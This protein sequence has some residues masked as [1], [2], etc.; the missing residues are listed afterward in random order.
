MSTTDRKLTR[1][2]M[3]KQEIGQTR[4]MGGLAALLVIVF[5]LTIYLPPLLQIAHE[6]SEFSRGLRATRR[7]QCA[8]LF[9]RLAPAKN[10]L[11]ETGAPLWRR[12]LRA[13]AALLREMHAYEDEL[14]NQSIFGRWIRKPVQYVMSGML[15][16]GNEKS[17][18]GRRPWLFYRPDV[19]HLLLPGFL[20]QAR[21]AAR[22]ASG[23]EWRAAPQPDPV[24]AILDFHRQL[25]ARGIELVLVP[26]PVKPMLHPDALAPTGR[27]PLYNRSWTNFLQRLQV[28]PRLVVFDPTPYLLELRRDGDVFLKTDTHWRPEA[29]QVVAARLAQTLRERG[30]VSDLPRPPAQSVRRVNVRGT[31]DLVTMLQLPA[32]Q[33]LF[34]QEDVALR[35]VLGPRGEAWRPDPAADILL[36]GDSFSNIYSLDALG[37]GASA[38]FAEQLSYEL[39][40]PLDVLVL[41]DN[42]AFAT[43][44]ALARELKRG[45]D[46]LA[47]KK[48]VIWQFAAREL[49]EGDWAFLSLEL[50]T[51]P[52]RAFVSPATGETWRVKATVLDAAP[53]PLPGTV[54]YKDHIV[55]LHLGD[56]RSADGRMTD[57]EALCY[58]LS[59]RDQVRTRAARLRPGDEID[60]LL[61]AWSDVAPQF[62]G[63]NRSELDDE[64]LQWA[65]PCWGEWPP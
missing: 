60:I 34:P 65:E 8:D 30:W 16:V 28:E 25:S 29:M 12:L 1:E 4:I 20:E 64:T 51:P 32:G 21:L 18:C 13:N 58:M 22:R 23:S 39:G 43:R 15:G 38:G 11:A 59:M 45:R 14:E 62:E 17:Y 46:R 50:G 42:G 57:G 53:V 24:P 48:L 47:G 36:L 44:A 6:Q 56:I 49:S 31:G 19:D 26:T 41:N 37:W 5:L 2:E 40:R 27:A 33:R 63:M 55:A 10:A 3:A 7:P 9:F 54:P 52:A 61:K 35:Q